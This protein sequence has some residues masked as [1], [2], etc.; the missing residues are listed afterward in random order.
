MNNWFQCKVKYVARND[1]G[2]VKNATEQYLVD[3]MSFTEAEGRLIEDMA[4][5][6]KDFTV[7]SVARSQ[8]TEVVFY[9]DTE[10]WFRSKVTYVTVDGDE[11]KEKKVTTYFLVNAN[12]VQ[13]AW[14]RTQEHLKE[15]LV[16]YQVPKI[17]ESPVIGVIEHKKKKKKE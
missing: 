3:A 12:D 9:G 8:I 13:E 6:L 2:L 7:M 11:E 1:N 4:E 16:P 15:M 17:E 5:G 10:K 14:D